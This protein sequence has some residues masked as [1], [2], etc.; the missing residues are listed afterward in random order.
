[1]TDFDSVM[2]RLS[3]S[4]RKRIKLASEITEEFQALPSIG[5]TRALQGGLRYGTVTQ[6]WGNR[7]GGKTALALGTM[8][9]AQAKGKVCFHM[10]A[11]GSFRK[12]W[13]KDLGVDTSKLI[14][15]RIKTFEDASNI[16]VEWIEAGA[17]IIT[18]DSISA[19]IPGSYLDEKGELKEQSKTKQIGQFS[20]DAGTMLNMF[21]KVNDHTLIIIISQVR[22]NI[23][24]Y[25]S[26]LGPMGGKS[27][28][29]H[30]STSIKLW[31][32][33]ADG[34]QLTGDVHFGDKIMTEKIGRPVVW[35]IDKDRGPG[36]N[37]SDTYD[38]FFKGDVLGIDNVKEMLDI[39]GRYGKIEK[40][41][42]WFI[43]DDD[44]FNG[45]RQAADYLR[46]HPDTLQR[47]WDDIVD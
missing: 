11:E 17:D 47:L 5:I 22:N 1:M 14:T 46:A 37:M 3:P 12:D 24:S 29:H 25:G 26:S 45:S 31:S 34:D 16:G 42:N 41:G 38:F 7:S 19:L 13:A 32:S 35:T 27:V 15:S 4:T 9:M 33:L 18:I 39:G 8:G 30:N 10:D 21:N 43:I 44:K 36:M 2:A 6:L 28:E 40:S 23:G 20:K